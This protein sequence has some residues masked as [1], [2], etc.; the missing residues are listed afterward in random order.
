MLGNLLQACRS[1]QSGGLLVNVMPA[2][3]GGAMAGG[4]AELVIGL[5]PQPR[6][7]EALE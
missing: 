7:G 1:G 3:G 6:N 2:A 5:C 4:A